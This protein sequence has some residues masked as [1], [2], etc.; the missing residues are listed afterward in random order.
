M[1]TS[2]A[3]LA[4]RRLLPITTASAI[5][6]SLQPP[7]SSNRKRA[8]TQ[9]EAAETKSQKNDVT[10]HRTPMHHIAH[11]PS[12]I[13]QSPQIPPLQK[14]FEEES[15]LTCLFTGIATCT[16]LS[17]YFAKI[18]LLEIPDITKEMSQEVATGHRRSRA[19][20]LVISAFWV[21]AGAYRWHLG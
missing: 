14:G 10:S 21:A 6:F 12:G 9:C 17:L 11:P 1:A 3:L 5:V 7:P 18:A 19:G 2:H 16:G 13:P 8:N 15:C 4:S 20:F